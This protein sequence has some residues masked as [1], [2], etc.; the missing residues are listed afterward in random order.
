M[1]LGSVTLIYLV[2]AFV[3]VPLAIG[4]GYE[5]Y[6]VLF[7][8]PPG[9]HGFFDR[10]SDALSYAVIPT[11]VFFFADWNAIPVVAVTGF[12]LMAI[13]FDKDKLTWVQVKKDALHSLQGLA[14]SGVLAMLGWQFGW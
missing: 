5:V 11:A 7:V 9:S 10:M 3:A 2:F 4:I 6:Q 13:H 14:A 8:D 12:Y 1:L